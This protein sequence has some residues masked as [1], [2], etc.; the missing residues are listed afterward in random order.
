LVAA[1][2]ASCAKDEVSESKP[3]ANPDEVS[4]SENENPENTEPQRVMPNLPETDFGGKTY[5]V[6]GRNDATYAQFINFEIDAETII[7]EPVNDAVYNR[8]RGLEEKYNVIIEQTLH[9][10]PAGSLQKLVKADEDVYSL[11]FII[12]DKIGAMAASGNFRDL[13]AMKYLDFEKPWWSPAINKAISVGNRLYY[14]TSDFNMMNKNRTYIMVFNKNMTT[15]YNL[16]NFYDLVYGNKWTV[17]KMV[18]LC[19]T[20]SQDIDGDGEMTAA[21]QWG[22]GMDSYNAFFALFASCDNYMF[23]KDDRDYPALS[24][25]NEHAISTVEKLL[26]LTNDKSMSYYCNEFQGKVSYDFWYVSTT[27]FVEGRLLFS[28]IFPHGL[29]GMA[30]ESTVDYGVLPF[31]KYDEKQAE[32]IG[33]AE[34]YHSALFAVPASV[35]DVDFA[36]F[37][38]EALSAV[39][40]YE[41]MPYYYEVSTKNKYTDDED[42]PKMLDIIF[43]GLRYDLGCVYNWGGINDLFRVTLP[44]GKENNFV[45]KY[46]SIDPKVMAAMEKTLEIFKEL[47]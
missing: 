41:V 31:P 17:D 23:T 29:K 2:F 47:P 12:Q 13:N 36:A 18:E 9:N 24:V 39:S 35:L 8:N 37:M 21:D 46:D 43:N 27:M 16:G 33:V 4:A 15:S 38:L 7:G 22:F 3:N 10:D 44:Q 25:K 1:V 20:V 32:Y 40:K 6:L 34:N 28:A 30:Q 5:K 11:A 42:S 45:S 14:T 19:K 26:K